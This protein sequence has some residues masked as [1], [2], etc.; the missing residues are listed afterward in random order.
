MEVKVMKS[1]SI[2]IVL[3][4]F[5]ICSTVLTLQLFLSYQ[6]GYDKGYKS[7]YSEGYGRAEDITRKL[8]VELV[9]QGYSFK[10]IGDIERMDLLPEGEKG[11]EMERQLWK[12]I[13]ANPDYKKLNS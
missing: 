4:V 8:R 13:I 6:K 7:G 12:K 9:R 2:A 5:L 3:S 10:Q 11:K 1:I